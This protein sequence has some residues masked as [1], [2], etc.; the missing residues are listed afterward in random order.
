[1]KGPL[2]RA[3][4]VGLGI[5]AVLGLLHVLGVGLPLLWM[6]VVAIG[7]VAIVV[8]RLG[9]RWLDELILALRTWLWQRESGRHHSFAGIALLVEEHAGQM[10]MS[11]ESLQRALR[12]RE[13]ENS[14]AARLVGRA[15]AHARH[16]NRGVLM[17]NVQAVVHHLA[18]MPRRTE[19]RV[20]R[21]RRYLEREVLYPASRRAGGGAAPPK[22]FDDSGS[23]RR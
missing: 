14:T 8:P 18:H 11:A 12:Q 5:A 17:L 3:A 15:S 9:V 20:I 7:T 1:M 6:L 4:L 19:P 10:W 13:D 23:A 22:G 21:L 16:N 2:Q